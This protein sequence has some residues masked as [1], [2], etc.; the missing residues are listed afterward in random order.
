MQIIIFVPGSMHFSQVPT[1]PACK[2]IGSNLSAGAG[3]GLK[4]EACAA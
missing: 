2:G 1:A 4:G 3:I